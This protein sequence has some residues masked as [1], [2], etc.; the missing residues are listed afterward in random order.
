MET[1]DSMQES[2]PPPTPQTFKEQIGFR[3]NRLRLNPKNFIERIKKKIDENRDF[4]KKTINFPDLQK[5]IYY[6][7]DQILENFISFLDNSLQTNLFLTDFIIC[8]SE[9]KWFLDLFLKKI[10]KEKKIGFFS[11]N[12]VLEILQKKFPSKNYCGYFIEKIP[13]SKIEDMIIIIIIEEF[14]CY[15]NEE[16]YNLTIETNNKYIRETIPFISNIFSGMA[17]FE[18]KNE[19]ELADVYLLLYEKDYLEIKKMQ[20]K[21]SEIKIEKIEIEALNTQKKYEHI[22]NSHLQIPLKAVNELVK[23]M[24][25]D[26]DGKISL[27]DIKEFTQKHYIDY[28]DEV[29]NI[30]FLW[31][32]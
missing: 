9:N 28:T 2:I 20:S 27:E 1:L 16:I 30:F 11:E 26:N 21:T 13:L 10:Y 29:K 31:K 22:S 32:N 24:D 3:I 5:T 4:D 8:S 15:N 6:A 19:N 18:L 12:L 25:F 14:L 17:I 7:D 23:K